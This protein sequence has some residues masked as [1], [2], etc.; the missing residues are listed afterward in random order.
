[1]TDT[2]SQNIAL[3]SWITLYMRWII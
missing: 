1:M 3:S 2:V